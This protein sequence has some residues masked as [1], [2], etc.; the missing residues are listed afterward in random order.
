VG[1]WFEL[2]RYTG[3]YAQEGDCVV[4]NLTFVQQTNQITVTNFLRM[5]QGGINIDV[6]G[7][8]RLSNPV[9]NLGA[10]RV[11]LPGRPEFDYWILAT[12]YIGYSIVWSC[13]DVPGT[14]TSQ[15]E[16]LPFARL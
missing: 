9:S 1:Q 7:E 6:A 16:C 11:L 5:L 8:A 12:D 15:G 14:T 13:L 2:Q 10:L 4:S 3:Q